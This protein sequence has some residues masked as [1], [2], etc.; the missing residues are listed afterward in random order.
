MKVAITDEGINTKEKIGEIFRNQ[1]MSYIHIHNSSPGCFN[2][3]VR[4]V[5]R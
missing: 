5:S 2:C 4:R 3:E 1:A